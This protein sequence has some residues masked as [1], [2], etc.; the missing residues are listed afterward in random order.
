[1]ST[2]EVQEENARIAREMMLRRQQEARRT[3]IPRF[4]PAVDGVL[5]SRIYL[6]ESSPIPILS[7]L[8]L[9]LKPGID[10]LDNSKPPRKLWDSALHYISSISGFCAVKWG[11]TLDESPTTLLCMIHWDSTVAWRKFQYSLGFSALI[12]LFESD[13]SNRCAKLSLLDLSWLDRAAI[14]DIVSVTFDAQDMSSPEL[15]VAFKESWNAHVVSVTSEY[16]GLRHSHIV[17]LEN[18]ASMFFDP[19]PAEAAAATTLATFTAFLA[20]D[21]EQYDGSRIEHLCNSFQPSLSSFGGNEPAILRKTVQLRNQ[22]QQKDH[23]PPRQPAMQ[24]PGLDSI[25]QAD[26]S[27]H[28]SADLVNLREHARLALTRSISDARAR[29]RL[30]PAPQGSFISQGELYE[31]NMP[32]TWGWQSRWGS[33]HGYHFVDVAWMYL[34]PNAVRTRGPQIYGQLSDEIGTLKGFVK[35]FWAR[36][37][38]N[39][40]KIAMFTVWNDEH[41]REA[42]LHEYRRILDDFA[43]LSIHLAASITQQAFPMARGPLGVWLDSRSYIELAT[44]YIPQGAHE[45]QLFE[46][47]YAAFDRMT[48]PSQIGGVPRACFV[49]DAG[50]W[51]PAEATENPDYQLFTGVIIWENPD[52]RIEWYGELFRLSCESYELFG[53]KLNALKLTAAGGVKS[54]FLALQRQ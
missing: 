28:C 43:G 4:G 8:E 42:A 11:P 50:G 45:R 52:A 41:A 36:D 19:T 9:N 3:V 25:L 2:P 30:F 48:V 31:G 39:K 15:R 44:F 38:E 12:G 29:I 21:G 47:A 5:W 32:M 49:S 22:L 53:H 16:E 13:V 24:A 10:I 6:D 54:R 35:A 26:V 34:K 51:E 18:N 27:R 46:Q 17:W 14:V 23:D 20:W 7:V 33:I 37:V 40:R 1:M